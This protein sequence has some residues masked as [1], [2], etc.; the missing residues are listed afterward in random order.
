[1]SHMWPP[2]NQIGFPPIGKTCEIL[3]GKVLSWVP[4]MRFDIADWYF[5]LNGKGD[6][7][8][9]FEQGG[10]PKKVI[11]HYH[12]F[13]DINEPLWH[14]GT[15]ERKMKK[16]KA[17]GVEHMVS[18][19][20]SVWGDMPYITQEYTGTVPGVVWYVGQKRFCNC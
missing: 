2:A 8:K 5:V 17:W 20:F 19:D 9:Y 10:D 6:L 7:G 16:L 11:V 1:M 3:Q 15:F 13:D 4:G 12:A 18:P 14:R